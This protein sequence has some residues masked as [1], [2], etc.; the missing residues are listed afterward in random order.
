ME[1]EGGRVRAPH[2]RARMMLE[3]FLTGGICNST[4]PLSLFFSLA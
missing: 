2:A 3:S 4:T 1:E